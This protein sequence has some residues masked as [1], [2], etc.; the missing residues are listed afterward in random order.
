M[1][2]CLFTV[3]APW[4]PLPELVADLPALGY[5]GVEI[6]WRSWQHDP[7]RP[8]SFWGNNP[9][10]LDWDDRGPGVQ[11]LAEALR[12]SGCAGASLA[13]YAYV[14]ETERCLAG[15]RVAAQLGCPTLRVRM[16]LFDPAVGARTQLA[17]ARRLLRDLAA[18]AADAG[19]RLLAEQH[20]GH[21]SAS[22]SGALRLVDGCDPAVVGVLF[23]P[24]NMVQEGGEALRMAIQLLGPYLQHVH[25]KDARL[26][27]STK[28]DAKR[29]LRARGE[30]TD[31]GQGWVDWPGVIAALRAEG[32]A[33][34]LS[35]KDF[36]PSNRDRS[37][38]AHQAAWVRGLVDGR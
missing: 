5:A 17:D 36:G 9:A 38:M 16:P 2:I 34:W 33:G 11:R 27:A 14:H 32:Y 1:R 22:A 21:L 29:L 7:S 25:V 6:P 12:A 30:H 3:C 23:D 37:A 26:T 18:P 31:L 10:V 13:S 8:P 19:V 4:A 20:D 35:V 28:P 15:L 24:A